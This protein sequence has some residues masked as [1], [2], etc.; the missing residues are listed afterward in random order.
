MDRFVYQQLRSTRAELHFP[1]W[2]RL[3]RTDRHRVKRMTIEELVAKRV[4]RLL[5]SDAPDSLQPTVERHNQKFWTFRE[6]LFERKR[7][8]PNYPHD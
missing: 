4:R 1:P 2:N 7:E 8:Q 6:W 3:R 5:A